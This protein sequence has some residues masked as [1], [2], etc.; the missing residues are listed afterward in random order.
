MK[1]DY[2]TYTKGD[3]FLDF[4]GQPMNVFRPEEALCRDLNDHQD[5]IVVQIVK[6]VAKSNT[7]PVKDLDRYT[8]FYKH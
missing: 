3:Y 2:K 1:Y 5:W 8:L 7:S 4:K 6:S